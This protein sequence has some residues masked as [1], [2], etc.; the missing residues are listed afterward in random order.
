MRGHVGALVGTD[1]VG[2][3]VLDLL[4]GSLSP[5]TY[6]N[7][8]AGMRRFTFFATMGGNLATCY[9]GRHAALYVKARPSLN[10][11]GQ[12]PPNLL[13]S[14]QQILLRPRQGA[15]GTG[16]TSN[17][18]TSRT[19]HASTTHHR[20]RHSHTNPNTHRTTNN[21]IRPPTLPR[22]YLAAGHPR[23]HQDLPRNSRTLQ[24]LLLFLPRGNRGTLPH[25]RHR[26][27]HDGW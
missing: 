16:T 21:T 8:G 3:L 27:R 25:G 19:R 5:T 20:P 2:D 17:G 9:C 24:Y 1:D 14:D 26:G 22:A 13:L 6:N 11:R 12:E 4:T 23:T 15:R 10:R 18:R 7:Y